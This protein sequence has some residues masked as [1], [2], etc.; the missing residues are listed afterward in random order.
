M[1][2]RV[3]I[4][5]ALLTVT[6][7]VAWPE[8]RVKVFVDFALG[9]KPCGDI[10]GDAS[11]E[12]ARKTKNLL[13]PAL[14]KL[15]Y[16]DFEAATSKKQFPR[17]DILLECLDRYDAQGQCEITFKIYLHLDKEEIEEKEKRDPF[18]WPYRNDEDY[19]ER[20]KD[21]EHREKPRSPSEW[22]VEE[23]KRLMKSRSDE[24]VEDVFSRIVIANSA[25]P[26]TDKQ[27]NWWVLPLSH[28]KLRAKSGT[29]FKIEGTIVDRSALYECEA[30]AKQPEKTILH[31]PENIWTLT[32]TN[33]EA[34]CETYH[35]QAP[36]D[37]DSISV[38]VLEFRL[39]EEELNSA[40]APRD[41][42][43]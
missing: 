3:V 29:R 14:S 5:L 26:V 43:E 10:H 16:L 6:S 19:L 9:P 18:L 38:T 36:E 30:T 40:Q 17:L 23:F 13:V 4:T 34:A 31:H 33:S 42:S 27:E 32:D 41:T 12:I 20:C 7:S 21:D 11:T 8:D 2:V 37:L 15:G 24:L 28:R 35:P 39:W 25:H 1:Y 22:Y